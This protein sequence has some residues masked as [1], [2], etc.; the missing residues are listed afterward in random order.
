METSLRTKVDEKRSTNDSDAIMLR[1]AVN[2]VRSSVVSFMP[3]EFVDR[4]IVFAVDSGNSE[5]CYR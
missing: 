2:L 3:N 1:R 5:L 4:L